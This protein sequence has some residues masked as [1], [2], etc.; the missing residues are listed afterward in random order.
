MD[1]D[2]PGS[3]IA[4][5]DSRRLILYWRSTPDGRLVFGKGGGWMRGSRV[6]ARFTGES[7]LSGS[8][9]SRMRRLYLSLREVPI[10]YSWNGP[11][12]YSSTGF[13]YFGPLTNANPAILVGT[14]Y[15]GNG[16]VPTCWAGASLA[17]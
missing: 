12:G 11:T 9:I 6:D 3:G 7:T 15:S 5:S 8:V 4:L 14:G 1:G 17:S 13:P 16:V 10:E 2:A